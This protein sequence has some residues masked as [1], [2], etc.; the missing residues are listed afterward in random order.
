MKAMVHRFCKLTLGWVLVFLGIIGW[1]LPIL[2]GTPFILLGVAILSTQ[3]DCL[4]NKI[5]SLKVRFPR[6]VAGLRMLK[7]NLAAKIR[8]AGTS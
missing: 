1:L 3:S 5:D 4:R 7:E 6:Q 8:R 2:P